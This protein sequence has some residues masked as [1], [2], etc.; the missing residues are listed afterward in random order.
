MDGPCIV[1]ILTMR[2]ISLTLL[3]IH[4]RNKRSTSAYVT[5][6]SLCPPPW[7]GGGSSTLLL[8]LLQR[9]QI[10]LLQTEPNVNASVSECS[11]GCLQKATMTQTPHAYFCPDIHRRNNWKR[12]TWR[13]V[14]WSEVHSAGDQVVEAVCPFHSSTFA[15]VIGPRSAE[16]AS[17]ACCRTTGP[18]SC[19][20]YAGPA[21]RFLNGKT[22]QFQQCTD[23]YTITMPQ[24]QMGSSANKLFCECSDFVFVSLSSGLVFL[25]PDPPVLHHRVHL[26]L[27]QFSLF[28]ELRSQRLHLQVITYTACAKQQSTFRWIPHFRGKRIEQKWKTCLTKQ[29]TSMLCWIFHANKTAR[30]KVN[31][32]KPCILPED[33]E[34]GC[35]S[36]ISPVPLVSQAACCASP[37]AP[38]PPP[39]SRCSLQN[40]ET[41]HLTDVVIGLNP[42]ATAITLIT[43]VLHHIGRHTSDYQLE[44]SGDESW[45]N[46]KSRCSP[47]SFTSLFKA[48]LSLGGSFCSTIASAGGSF[49]K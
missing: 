27:C 4:P 1:Q 31:E 21:N 8:P 26:L 15:R 16:P 40:A 32:R 33:W 17:R 41:S 45:T 35:L 20:A 18:V 3:F 34:S 19:A 9:G 25:H 49:R 28:R 7:G 10:K 30:W 47:F 14:S 39:S 44:L 38:P 24:T 5:R 36:C 37:Q 13:N 29:G 11:K 42:S 12:R 6:P 23:N 46:A 22:R 48:L 2:Q 43:L